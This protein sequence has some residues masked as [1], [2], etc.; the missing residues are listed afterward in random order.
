[1]VDGDNGVWQYDGRLNGGL[2]AADVPASHC[3]ANDVFTSSTLLNCQGS[4]GSHILVYA[5]QEDSGSHA[6]YEHPFCFAIITLS[7]LS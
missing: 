3:L 4:K 1:L 7:V 2:P 6:W 5:L